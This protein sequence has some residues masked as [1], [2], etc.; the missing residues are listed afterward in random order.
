MA[1]S[2]D[3]VDAGLESSEKSVFFRVS[4]TC[5]NDSSY[6]RSIFLRGKYRESIG[7]CLERVIGDWDVVINRITADRTD[8]PTDTPVHILQS[9]GCREISVELVRK[10]KIPIKSRGLRLFSIV[11][12]Y[13]GISMSSSVHVCL[14][15]FHISLVYDLNCVK[16]KLFKQV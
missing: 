1:S 15:L 6:S 8:T 10:G 9:Y 2:C 11:Y 16:L 13:F 5:F 3:N 4:T 7:E 14:P 12:I